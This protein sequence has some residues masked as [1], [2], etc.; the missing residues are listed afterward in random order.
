MDILLYKYNPSLLTTTTCFRATTQLSKHCKDFVTSSNTSHH[1]PFSPCVA[2]QKR[3]H[4]GGCEG[5]STS[6]GAGKRARAPSGV[7]TDIFIYVSRSYINT[8]NVVK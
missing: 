1:M 6:C 7:E 3:I 2:K 4:G 8:S 5:S